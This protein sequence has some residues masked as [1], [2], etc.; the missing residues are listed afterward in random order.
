MLDTPIDHHQRP[1]DRGGSC[2]DCATEL[3]RLM[4]SEMPPRGRQLERGERIRA[5]M[6][7][8]IW[9]VLNG[10]VSTCT[11]LR[12]G[13]RQIVCLSVPGE[14]VGPVAGA[15][16][17]E[18]WVEAL[19]PSWLCELDLGAEIADRIGTE[20]VCGAA[21]FQVA[22]E[23]VRRASAHLVTLGRLDAMERICLFLADMTGR[24]GRP[25]PEGFLVRLPMGRGDIADYLGLTPETVS[26]VLGR[27]KKDRLLTFFSP[28]EFLVPD[29][30][31]LKARA[32]LA[33]LG[34]AGVKFPLK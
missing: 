1:M 31:A 2:R 3:C 15:D 29:V 32:P 13:R 30:K 11:N 27:V 21:L 18:I 16:E 12:D 25:T 19:A 33:P 4:P 8:R 10:L 34:I 9:T 14:V 26:R 23:Q 20:P 7:L 24:L 17:A 22:Q 6:S 28:T 5:S